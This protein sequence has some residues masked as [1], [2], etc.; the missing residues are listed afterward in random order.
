[1]EKKWR[2]IPSSEATPL[3]LAKDPD[4]GVSLTR[5]QIELLLSAR[6]VE[7]CDSPTVAPDSPFGI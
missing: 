5:E 4:L 2:F 1:M 6:D 7:E 3:K